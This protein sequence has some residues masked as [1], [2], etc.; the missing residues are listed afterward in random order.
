MPRR[1]QRNLC[2]DDVIHGRLARWADSPVSDDDFNLDNDK[3]VTFKGKQWVR[4]F[5]EGGMT[6]HDYSWKPSSSIV[7]FFTRLIVTTLAKKRHELL[8]DDRERGT[9]QANKE[10]TL[11]LEWSGANDLI[12]VNARPSRLEAERAVAARIDN[13]RRLIRA[14][15]RQFIL[16]NMPDLSLTPRYQAE[17]Q[18][19]Q[20]NASRWSRY[21]NELLAEAVADLGQEYPEANIRVFDIDSAFQVIYN[22]P[23][24]YG[25]DPAKLHTPYTTSADFDDPSDGTSP[26]TGYLYYDD[27]HPSADAH[28]LLAVIFQAFVSQ[29]YTFHEPWSQ[30]E[31]LAA[32]S[33]EEIVAMFRSS[34]R[35]HLNKKLFTRLPCF[36]GSD[37]DYRRASLDEILQ[38]ALQG[39]KLTQHV[40]T[41]IGLFDDQG[42]PVMAIPAVAAAMRR[43]EQEHAASSSSLTG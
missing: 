38:H 15:Y 1:K 35:S 9:T 20:A 3:R 16:F 29:F 34:Y 14:G 7:R 21:M 36:S 4:T 37:W 18:E 30:R 6:A 23:A 2:D 32:T 17:S 12:T 40:L 19:E 41:R 22:N 28:A 25:F 43:C 10:K 8:R 5:C 24:K 42:R 39:G 13:A 31:I 11:I 33:E 26:A 27:V